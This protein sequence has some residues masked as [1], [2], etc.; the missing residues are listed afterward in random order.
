MR[1]RA[2]LWTAVEPLLLS[3]P[4]LTSTVALFFTEILCSA[5]RL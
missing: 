5:R 4:F 1:E 3:V 2:P